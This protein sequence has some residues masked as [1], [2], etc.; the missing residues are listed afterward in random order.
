MNVK[1]NSSNVKSTKS[2][3]APINGKEEEPFK[4]MIREDIPLTGIFNYYDYLEEKI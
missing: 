4:E 3:N 1:I 2:A